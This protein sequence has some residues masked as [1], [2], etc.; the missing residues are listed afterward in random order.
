MSASKSSDAAAVLQ[1]PVRLRIIQQLGGRELTTTQLRQT[2]PDVAQ[3]TLYRHVAAL[4]ESDLVAVTD[5]RRVRGA[6]E[7][8]LAIGD[9]MAT[10][11]RAELREMSGAQLRT[12]FL[13]F[14]AGVAAEFDRAVESADERSRDLLGFTQVPLYVDESDLET[15]QTALA[16]LLRPYLG[17]SEV[18][19][20]KT[21]VNLTTVL[22]PDPSDPS[23]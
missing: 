14:L 19:G 3:A 2:L 11:D 8:T 23:A 16:D 12:S 7:R 17:D 15:I 21:R 18:G 20:G 1:H 4:I 13:N 5:E 6:V 22:L 9:R 10:V